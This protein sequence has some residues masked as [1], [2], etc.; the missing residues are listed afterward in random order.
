MSF[1][2]PN[3]SLIGILFIVSTHSGPQLIYKYP[4]DL[5]T[6]TYSN[7]F[8]KQNNL[9][10][11]NVKLGVNNFND[12]DKQKIKESYFRPIDDIE[13]D[14]L[15][16]YKNSDEEDEDELNSQL[17]DDC[18]NDCEQFGVSSRNWD[19]KHSNYY[20]GT[21]LDLLRFLDEQD[22]KRKEQIQFQQQNL[23][24]E[25]ASKNNQTNV[26]DTNSNHA[27]LFHTFSKASIGSQ[28]TT[29]KSSTSTS[30]FTSSINNDFFEL[31]PSYLCE[32]LS[33]PKKMCNTR[34]E[35]TLND[36]IFIGLPIHKFNDGKWRVDDSTPPN[37][38]SN[39]QE[40]YKLNQDNE[41]F[42]PDS[43]SI[44]LNMFHM[45]FIM[46]PAIVENNYRVDEMYHHVVSKISIALRYE[47]SKHEYITKQTENILLLRDTIFDEH[48]L[49]ERSQL[50]KLIKD[51]YIMI[52]SS[53][54][55]TLLIN[56]R[57]RTFQIPI[58]TEFDAL[59]DASVPF[60][61]RSYLSSS[62]NLLSSFGLV[63]PGETLRYDQN[64]TKNMYNEDDVSYDSLIYFAI[65]LLDDPDS[66]IK[67]LKTQSNSKLARFIKI[68]QPTETLIKLSL[69]NSN[70][71]INQ[72]KS[73]AYHLIYW[74][75]GRMIQPISPRSVYVTSPMAPLTMKLYDDIPKFSHQFPTLP[76]LP[77]FLKLLSPQVKKPE[78][79]ARIIPSKDHRDSY[80]QAL[81]WLLRNGYVTELQ[82]FIW[83]KIPR[84][85]KIKVEEEIENETLS[86]RIRKDSKATVDD[87]KNVK[88]TDN[89]SKQETDNVVNDSL[90]IAQ[91][92]EKSK[93][94]NNLS[95]LKDHIRKNASVNLSDEE[96]TIILDPGRATT[97][98]R[99]WISTIIHEEHKLSS[100]LTTVFYKILKYMN[101]KNSVEM[102]ML[103]ENVSRSDIK[104]L[105]NALGDNIILVK[106]W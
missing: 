86:K 104:K 71:T 85:I 45:V 6:S 73:F 35:V 44:N 32:M 14:E 61:P 17:V 8:Q 52:S 28:S 69:K 103:K 78:S 102:L 36:K 2:L 101:G 90:K 22:Y 26:Y 63:N 47:Q 43:N 20:L 40:S 57:L 1:N 74:R 59:P 33:P 50:C 105:F 60:I 54:I 92:E 25:L 27:R 9:K 5:K 37:L 97:L 83:L 29:A 99:R 55:A 106:H 15:Y 41:S 94:Q 95:N 16:D 98:E 91:S 88:K 24:E 53:K 7:L 12:N 23:E 42:S 64:F 87:S 84:K 81:A 18:Y 21:K 77:H 48:L 100:E 62:V 38:A 51:C 19:S 66:I 79:F 68:I 76:S 93:I 67:D 49:T 75:K 82:T 65:L 11:Y 80:I 10:N 96:A 13:D 3:P 46:N 72:I 4:F 39:E 58:K 70:L 34:F 31:E 89:S 56:N 30:N